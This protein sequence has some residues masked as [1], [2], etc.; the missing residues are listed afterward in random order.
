[1]EG[2][3]LCLCGCLMYSRHLKDCGTGHSINPYGR[4]ELQVLLELTISDIREFVVVSI[5]L[6]A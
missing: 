6:V 3:E 5:D 2:K 1:M 4:N